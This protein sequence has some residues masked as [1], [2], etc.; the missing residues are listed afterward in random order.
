MTNRLEDASVE[1][2]ERGTDLSMLAE[3]DR[4]HFA[5]VSRLFGSDFF[6]TREAEERERDR[7]LA[8]R[9]ADATGEI[10][11]TYEQAAARLG[12]VGTGDGGVFT[13]GDV[14]R[15]AVVRLPRRK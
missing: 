3:A 4:E 13:T 11:E 1:T 10:L 5:I 7:I 15:H 9:E 14:M 8:Q 2:T 6:S 12:L